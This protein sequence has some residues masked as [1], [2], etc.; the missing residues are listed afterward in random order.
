MAGYSNKL[1]FLFL[2]CVTFIMSDESFK[3]KIEGK[4]EKTE[5]SSS[6]LCKFNFFCNTLVLTLHLSIHYY[7]LLVE[8]LLHI[9]RSEQKEAV[10]RIVGI[11][12][13]EKQQKLLELVITKI[14]QVSHSYL[15]IH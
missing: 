12:S 9:K 6:A 3:N 8:R 1:L 7:F 10:Q 4:P 14:M 11:K 13:V 15:A 5:D 2:L